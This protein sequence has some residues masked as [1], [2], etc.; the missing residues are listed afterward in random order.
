M[1][2]TL[3]GLI[4][5]IYN[6]MNIIAREQV[7]F[8]PAVARDSSAERAAV[9]QTVTSP[10][11]GA[12]ALE[13]ITPAAFAAAPPSETVGTV[14]MTIQKSKSYPF[15][16][17]GEEQ[18]AASGSM[19]NINEQRIAQGFRTITN[20][21]EADLAALHISASRAYGTYNTTPFGTAGDLSDFAQSRKILDDNGAPQSDFHLVMGS[22]AAANIRGK[23]SGLFRVNEA[24]TDDL[25]RR[26]AL[27]EVQGFDLHTSAQLLTSSAGTMN[28]ATTNATGYAKGSTAITLALAGTGVAIAGDIITFAGD[29]NKYVVASVAFAGANPAA[30][31][32]ITLQEP[33]LRVAI[34]AAAT[35]IT[36]T[37][38]TSRNMFFHRSAIQLATRAPAMPD[39]GDSSDDVMTLQDPNSGITYEFCVYR[40]KRQVRYEI[41]LAWGVKMVMP[42]FAGILIGA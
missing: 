16:I 20:A 28:G 42:R 9:G 17:T 13:D 25:L 8:I 36:V 6:S 40:Q 2:V 15:G 22:G 21:V 37:P 19:M 33:G 27:G 31:D 35:A 7:G 41:N 32:V 14:S 34:S 12:N 30:G 39:G 5:T 38:A 29:I 4:P 23:Q 3:T 11:V 18:M 1:A 24:G 26:G 10:V